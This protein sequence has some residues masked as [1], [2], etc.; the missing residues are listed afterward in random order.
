MKI[1]EKNSFL[2]TKKLKEKPVF[3]INEKSFKPSKKLKK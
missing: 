3:C 2:K 1:I